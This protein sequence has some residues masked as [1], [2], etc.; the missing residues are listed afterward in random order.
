MSVRSVTI[1]V[2]RAPNNDAATVQIRIRLVDLRGRPLLSIP[3]PGADPV[4]GEV[5]I[6]STGAEQTVEL[7]PQDEIYPASLYAVQVGVGGVEQRYKAQIAA[8]EVALTWAEFIASGESIS[9]PALDVWL[10]HPGDAD[11]HLQDEER[12]ALDAANAPTAANPV[13]TLA[14]IVAAGG[15]DMNAEIYDPQTI[16]DD[17]FAL[18]HATGTIDGGVF[19]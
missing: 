7:I 9:A 12:P 17:V 19:T 14:D 15:G 2:F 8:G 11:L 1:P 6:S 5:P 4:T 10:V 16:S 13:A 3:L 18:E